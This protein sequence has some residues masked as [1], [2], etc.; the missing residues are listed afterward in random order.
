MEPHCCKSKCTLMQWNHCT[1]KCWTVIFSLKDVASLQISFWGVKFDCP[2]TFLRRCSD[3]ERAFLSQDPLVK[4]VFAEKNDPFSLWTHVYT[5]K[6]SLG[7]ESSW[8]RRYKCCTCNFWSILNDAW[9]GAYEN[10]ESEVQSQHLVQVVILWLS[11]RHNSWPLEKKSIKL[12]DIWILN[13][14]SVI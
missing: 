5:W 1:S 10:P 14:F 4:Q 3:W 9:K 6:V 12:R 7:K 8:C 2:L 13:H 11:M